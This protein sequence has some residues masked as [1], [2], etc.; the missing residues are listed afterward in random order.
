LEFVANRIV[1]PN[2]SIPGRRLDRHLSVAR[3]IATGLEIIGN[4]AVEA[5]PLAK[6]RGEDADAA[7]A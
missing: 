1:S 3:S 7:A 6:L 2:E 4:C 5:A